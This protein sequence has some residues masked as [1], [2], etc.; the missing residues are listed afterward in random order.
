MFVT[1]ESALGLPIGWAVAQL[2]S[3]IASGW[4]DKISDQAYAAGLAVL[5]RAVPPVDA[6]GLPRSIR[7]RLS[8]PRERMTGMAYA[9]RWEARGPAGGLFPALDAD[10]SLI[11]VDA[12]RT[13]LAIVACYRLQPGLRLDRLLLSRAAQMT[14]Q[15]VVDGLV[16][17]IMQS[18]PAWDRPPSVRRSEPLV[19]T[20]HRL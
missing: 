9:L 5:A 8:G 4:F 15:S 16:R 13:R 18:V 6:D 20:F 3:T 1:E 7:V 12:I 11:R 19:L 2:G 10:L 17:E 14:L